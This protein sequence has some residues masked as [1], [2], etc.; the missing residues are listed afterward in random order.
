MADTNDLG[1]QEKKRLLRGRILP[2]LTLK[3]VE[4]L[5]EAA[6]S[7]RRYLWF[8][9]GAILVI[10]VLVFLGIR[11]IGSNFTFHKIS[12]SW[13]KEDVGSS[14]ASYEVFNNQ[15]LKMTR[16]GVAAISAGGEI[17]WNYGYKM[18]S[19]QARVNGKYGA[20]ADI[21]SETAVIFGP[22]GV[23]GTVTTN[24]PILNFAV[25]SHGVVAL[26]LDEP[27]VNYIYFYD[28]NGAELDI[29]I[30]TKL[31]GDG[32]P[33]DL[34]LSPSGTGL[35]TS[36]VYMDQGSMQNRVVFYNFDVGKSDSNRIVGYFTYGETMFPEVKYL[37][38]HAAVA[39]GDA[40]VDF[41]SLRNESNP[42]LVTSIPFET[43]IYSVFTGEDRV[44][45]IAEK[46]GG[47]ELHV[48]DGA[49]HAV[50]TTEIT[51]D[52]TSVEFSG[53]NVLMYNGSDCQILSGSGGVRFE[54]S[55][56]GAV[57]KIVMTGS[58]DALMFS[59]TT[60]KKIRFR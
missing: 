20:V 29:R 38:D 4:E 17:L 42:K 37:T 53:E 3:D 59:G 23:T 56:D 50:Y 2:D 26:E 21:Q 43:E 9:R 60:C 32:F 27:D 10:A 47:R 16:E 45:V 39:F 28:K 40:Q 58:R 12:V 25:S 44:G 33:M 8:R 6:Q 57:S 41:Y 51:F 48:Y 52:Y 46:D 13:E 35:M 30:K 24:L 7:H 14:D 19:P 5:D 34:S 1:R 18:T 22:E 36:V 11:S 55:M 15:V 49:G 54:G 31:A